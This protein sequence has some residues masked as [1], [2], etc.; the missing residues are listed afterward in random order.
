MSRLID[1]LLFR[2][3]SSENWNF[4]TL[5]KLWSPARWWGAWSVVT[6]HQHTHILSCSPI[7]GATLTRGYS[8]RGWEHGKFIHIPPRFPHPSGLTVVQSWEHVIPLTLCLVLD[9]QQ[10]PWHQQDSR[11]TLQRSSWTSCPQTTPLPS[12]QE[13]YEV[14]DTVRASSVSSV[15]QLVNS[16]DC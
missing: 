4:L 15:R 2:L 14:F 6:S 10:T 11:R 13:D 16:L 3:E 7:F 5:S 1:V 8:L 9:P 12:P